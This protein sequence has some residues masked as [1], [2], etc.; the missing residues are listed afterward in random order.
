MQQVAK[1]QEVTD[2]RFFVRCI[3]RHQDLVTKD[4]SFEYL[5]SEGE[6]TVMEALDAL[7]FAMS[8]PQSKKT[9]CNHIFLNFASTLTVKDPATVGFPFSID[10]FRYEELKVHILHNLIELGIEVGITKLMEFFLLIFNFK[11]LKK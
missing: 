3:I 7:E 1:G 5:E 10:P 8:H 2:Y 9:D 6:R 4:A 11:S